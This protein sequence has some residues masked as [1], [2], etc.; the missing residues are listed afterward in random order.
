MNIVKNK[1]F[2]IIL[3][4]NPFDVLKEKHGYERAQDGEMNENIEI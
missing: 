1:K 4:C 3:G 2:K